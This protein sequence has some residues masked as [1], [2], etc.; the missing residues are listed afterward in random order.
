MAVPKTLVAT[1]DPEPER[2]VLYAHVAA[3]FRK[4]LSLRK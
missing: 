4:M 2:Q 1:P 3:L